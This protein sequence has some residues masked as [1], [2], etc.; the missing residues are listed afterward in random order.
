MRT[1][2][3]VATAMI[4]QT[5]LDKRYR[6]GKLCIGKSKISQAACTHPYSRKRESSCGKI[7]KWAVRRRGNDAIR[8]KAWIAQSYQRLSRLCLRYSHSSSPGCS[9]EK[10]FYS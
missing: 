8:N 6:A 10:A 9:E 4:W 5:I 7:R 1:F 2:S 3:C